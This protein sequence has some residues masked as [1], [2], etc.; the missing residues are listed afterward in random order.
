MEAIQES[1]ICKQKLSCFVFVLFFPQSSEEKW[2]DSTLQ[3][4][5]LVSMEKPKERWNFHSLCR[6]PFPI[7]LIIKQ[8]GSAAGSEGKPPGREST[9]KPW[10][11]GRQTRCPFSSRTLRLKTVKTVFLTV[12]PLNRGLQA[13]LR[14]TV[15]LA[16]TER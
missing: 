9:V 5:F 12:V 1:F 3:C 11:K 8:A 4:V 10:G 2:L 7:L 16:W 6:G 13:S 15:P 14:D